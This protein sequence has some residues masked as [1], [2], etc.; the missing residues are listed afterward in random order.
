MTHQIVPLRTQAGNLRRHARPRT[1]ELAV[2]KLHP[3]NPGIADRLQIGGD[4]GGSHIPADEV[5][6]RFRM[7][8]LRRL[9]KQRR[10]KREPVP[11]HQQQTTDK[12][13]CFLHNA[14]DYTTLPAPL[15]IPNFAGSGRVPG[16]QRGVAGRDTNPRKNARARNGTWLGADARNRTL[17]RL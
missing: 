10:V 1:A 7:M 15:T 13:V 2:E 17:P 11:S 16:R 5:E 3:R 9:A 14:F 12:T 4:T 6:P 8:F